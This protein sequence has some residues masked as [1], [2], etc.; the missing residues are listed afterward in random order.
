VARL[1]RGTTSLIRDLNRAAILGLVSDQGRIARVEIAR[2]LALSP[3]AVTDIIRE[4][5]DDGLVQE[6]EQATS[7]GGRRPILLGLVGRAAQAIGVKIAAD[8]LALVRVA[9]DG[10]V[11]ARETE[12]FHASQ[13]DALERLARWLVAMVDGA[14]AYPGRLLGV[15]LGVPGIVDSSGV[16]QAPML[17]WTDL[18]M[19][20]TL[21]ARLSVP[22]LVDNDVNTLAVAERLYG[23]GRGLDHT[24]TVTIGRGVGLGIVVAG[25]LYRGARGGAGEF[26]HVPIADDGP[27]C[28]CGRRGCLEAFVADPA[29]VRQAIE[30]GVVDPADPQPVVALRR[31]ADAGEPLAIGIYRDAGAILGRAVAGLVNVLSPQR[32]ILSGEGT[33]V[34]PH[35]SEAFESSLRRAVFPPLA[36]VPVEVDPWDDA[37]WARGAAALVLR[38]TFAVPLYERQTEDAVRDRLSGPRDA[39]HASHHGERARS[40]AVTGAT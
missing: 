12:P 16:V 19:G 36:D 37:K 24:I 8:H 7:S 10:S 15:G 33:Q 39:R 9:L 28:S 21:G 30:A 11:L 31:A 14:A 25:D 1:R 4:L 5:V 3:A 35:L 40:H 2:H 22:V 38:A 18:A 13:P 6:V 27:F 17:G 20:P 26:G 29:L 23:L 32:I 34:W